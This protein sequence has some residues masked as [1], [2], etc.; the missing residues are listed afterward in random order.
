[1]R[2]FC[3]EDFRCEHGL[4][5]MVGVGSAGMTIIGMLLFKEEMTFAKIICIAFIVLGSIGLNFID[6]K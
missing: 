1:M 5:N 2:K 6:G 4:C 3:P